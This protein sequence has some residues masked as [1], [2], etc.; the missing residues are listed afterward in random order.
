MYI[1]LFVF[2]RTQARLRRN[3]GIDCR[4]FMFARELVGL[5]GLAAWLATL[6]YLAALGTDRVF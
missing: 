2:L 1:P 3:R 5:V 4:I 6:F